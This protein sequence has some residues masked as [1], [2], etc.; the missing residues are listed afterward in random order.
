MGA[1][2]GF[3]LS[4]SIPTRNRATYVRSVAQT[5]LESMP[6]SVEIVISDNSD[7]IDYVLQAVASASH[8]LKYHH[9]AEPLSFAANFNIAL[10]LCS[11]EFVTAIGDDDYVLPNIVEVVQLARSRGIDAVVYEFSAVYYWP[12][13]RGRTED[14]GLL[15]IF[16]AGDT[17]AEFV[18]QN[19]ELKAFFES[20]MR[21]YSKTRLARIY[22]GVVSR[23][24]VDRVQACHGHLYGGLSPDIYSSVLLALCAKRVLRVGMPLSIPGIS[25][26]SGSGQSASGAHRGALTSAPHFRGTQDYRWEEVVPR[27]YSVE[28]IWGESAIKAVRRADIT[29]INSI[30]FDR[31][32]ANALLQNLRISALI[33]TSVRGLLGV[34]RARYSLM[35]V[36]IHLSVLAQMKALNALHR[37]LRRQKKSE[38][39]SAA[40]ISEAAG[41]VASLQRADLLSLT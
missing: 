30:D 1:E 20:G 40:N 8:R 7:E 29:L 27:F 21:D 39:L 35:R 14:A 10:S 9:T 3:T 26:K 2:A 38:T 16:S 18:D 4:I 37:A 41:F 22:H 19:E 33:L 6:E 32:L 25:P 36:A 31:F 28:S 12:G 17:R 11:G 24:L 5:L 34:D 13:V 23:E 15:R